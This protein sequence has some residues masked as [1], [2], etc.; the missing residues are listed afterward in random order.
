MAAR[1]PGVIR[2]ILTH[3][4]YCS[5]YLVGQRRNGILH[6]IDNQRRFSSQENIAMVTMKM[7]NQ[8]LSRLCASFASDD[9]A[10]DPWTFMIKLIGTKGATRYSYRNWVENTPAVVH[11][12]TYSAYPYT[13]RKLE[14]ISLNQYWSGRATFINSR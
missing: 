8:A 2:Q 9:H 13:I 6:E 7:K 3:H 4:A 5:L 14:N 11:S 10:G 12:Q 1:Y